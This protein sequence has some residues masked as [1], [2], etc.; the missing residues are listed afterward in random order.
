MLFP[1]THLCC[2]VD[3]NDTISRLFKE[4]MAGTF[5]FLFPITNWKDYDDWD[6]WPVDCGIC[7]ETT[8]SESLRRNPSSCQWC[9]PGS[10]YMD[11]I[12]IG[13]KWPLW[14]L[15]CSK[16]IWV[17]PW[18]IWVIIFPTNIPCAP[19]YRVLLRN[20]NRTQYSSMYWL[21]VVVS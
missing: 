3:R 5:Y 10:R 2:D 1:A 16:Y 20:T 9:H 8:A 19:N 7:K 15:T 4:I 21:A 18:L 11:L 14:Y 17:F 6:H 12:I 13:S